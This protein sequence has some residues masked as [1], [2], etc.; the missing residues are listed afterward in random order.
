[1]KDPQHAQPDHEGTGH[2]KPGVKEK[3]DGPK[4]QGNQGLARPDPAM[5]LKPYDAIE[6][7]L[8]HLGL[9]LF[10]AAEGLARNK[11]GTKSKKATVRRVQAYDFA[12]GFLE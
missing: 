7:D 8:V 2:G 11:S 4:D 6:R 9:V 10:I 3:S 12:I 5:D 1:M